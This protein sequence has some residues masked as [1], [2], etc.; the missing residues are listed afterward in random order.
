MSLQWVDVYVQIYFQIIYLATSKSNTKN[1]IKHLPASLTQSIFSKLPKI[2]VICCRCIGSCLLPLSY[3]A[4][5]ISFQSMKQML[6][7]AK[8]ELFI[9]LSMISFR[10]L[11]V[12]RR[13]T[14]ALLGTIQFLRFIFLVRRY[15]LFLVSKSHKILLHVGTTNIK[16]HEDLQTGW[17]RNMDGKKGE[18]WK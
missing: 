11:N 16:S 6:P 4:Y 18:A 2:A 10:H 12:Y 13:F 17:A 1:T 15:W 8:S 7:K 14:K 9:F 3:D 5:V